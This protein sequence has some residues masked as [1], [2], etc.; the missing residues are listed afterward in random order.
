[1]IHLPVQPMPWAED[2]EDAT[3]ELARPTD[4]EPEP[5]ETR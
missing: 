2:G 1:M 5:K 3:E 4:E